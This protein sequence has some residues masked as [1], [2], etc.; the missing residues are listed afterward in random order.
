MQPKRSSSM[1]FVCLTILAMLISIPV[2]VLSIFNFGLI[3]RSYNG[4]IAIITFVFG[5]V[6]ILFWVQERRQKGPASTDGVPDI[7]VTLASSSSR[8]DTGLNLQ[9]MLKGTSDP[10]N[11]AALFGAAFEPINF[12]VA[13]T[14]YTLFISLGISVAYIVGFAI[15]TD[16]TIRGGV[17]STLPAERDPKMTYPW[18]INIQIAQTATMGL[19][20]VVTLAIVLSSFM[21]RVRVV[22]EEKELREEVEYGLGA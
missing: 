1:S 17:N 14:M 3:C 5:T 10:S 20:M 19:Q 11:A 22:E 6:F 18:N 16:I 9:D 4:A 7:T 21:G 2:G 13:N 8:S 15:M 12:P